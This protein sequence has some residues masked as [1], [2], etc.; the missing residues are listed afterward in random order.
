MPEV[1]DSKKFDA[2]VGG[3]VPA[4]IDFWAEWCGPCRMLGPIFEEL[5]EEFKGRLNFGKLNIDENNEIAS[6]FEVM[7]I[8]CMVVFRNGK[9]IGRI[10][11]FVPKPALKSKI[12]EILKNK[13]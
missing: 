12:E 8:P 11:G 9:E 7:S 1:L 10:V 5:S 4:I 3:K 13:K 2:F 6:R